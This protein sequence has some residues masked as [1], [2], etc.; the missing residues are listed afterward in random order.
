MNLLNKKSNRHSK[1]KGFMTE[2]IG[3][4]S[5]PDCNY[6]TKITC[7]ECKYGPCGGRKNPVAK[8]NQ[9]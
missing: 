2:D 9:L 3:W 7:E 6:N 4:G 1:C 8:Y 5:E